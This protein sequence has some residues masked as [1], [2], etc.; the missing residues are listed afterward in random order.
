MTAVAFD[1]HRAIKRLEAAGASPELAEAVLQVQQEGIAAAIDG[2][3]LATKQ[4]IREARQEIR[5]VRQEIKDLGLR[6]GGDLKLVRW[7]VGLSFALSV[8]ILSIL[9][10]L[11]FALP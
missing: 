10:R 11:F 9:A 8:G 3:D 2:A 4:D 1:T 5:D 6:F 7:M